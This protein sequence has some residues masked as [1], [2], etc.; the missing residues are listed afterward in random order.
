MPGKDAYDLWLNLPIDIYMSFYLFNLTNP[1]E[2]EAGD[3]PHLA[4]VGPFTYKVIA[5]ICYHR[6]KKL[7]LKS[8]YI[9]DQAEIIA[10]IHSLILIYS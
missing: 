2:F 4:E 6:C 1:N 10:I 5:S 7:F 8:P 9:Q 3:K